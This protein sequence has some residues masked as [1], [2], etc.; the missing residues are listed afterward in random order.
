MKKPE[1][2]KEQILCMGIDLLKRLAVQDSDNPGETEARVR[3]S[4]DTPCIFEYDTGFVIRD[5]LSYPLPDSRMLDSI[6]TALEIPSDEYRELNF[7]NV[8]IAVLEGDRISVRVWMPVLYN[9]PEAYSESRT[10]QKTLDSVEEFW[11]FYKQVLSR[12]TLED[13]LAMFC[14]SA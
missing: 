5:A 2:V 13:L 7:V 6:A 10:C 1:A 14:L 12:P 8:V 3:C 9:M 4:E 11:A